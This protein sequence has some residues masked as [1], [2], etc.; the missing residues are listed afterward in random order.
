MSLTTDSFISIL[1]DDRVKDKVFD[2]LDPL[3][4]IITDNLEKKYDDLVEDVTNL[5]HENDLLKERLNHC[6]LQQENLLQNSFKDDLIINGLKSSASAP[7]EDQV[8][9]FFKDDLK[10]KIEKSDISTSH[11]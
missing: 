2:I 6:D 9:S 4:D 3:F 8:L 10:V 11:P 1:D 5:R 7:T